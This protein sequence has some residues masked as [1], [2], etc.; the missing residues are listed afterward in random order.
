M[1]N[2]GLDAAIRACMEYAPDRRMGMTANQRLLFR[3]ACRAG[4][5]AR[6]HLSAALRFARQGNHYLS[7][8]SLNSAARHARHAAHLAHRMMRND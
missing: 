4:T 3:S 2:P 5:D 7:D 8:R 6:R 1:I